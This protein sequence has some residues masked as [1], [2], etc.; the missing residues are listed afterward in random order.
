[1]K[2]RVIVL[3]ASGSIGTSTAKV[4]RRLPEEMQIVG[5]AVNRSVASLLEQVAEFQPE[6]VAVVDEAAAAEV[7]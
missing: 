1:M 2:K 4:A 6:A 5:L 7:A 3:G